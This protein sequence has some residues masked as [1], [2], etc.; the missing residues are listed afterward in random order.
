[1]KE[2]H[3]KLF[4]EEY[5]FMYDSIADTVDRKNEINPM[6]QSYIDKVNERRIKLGV[7][8]YEITD[9]S[10][11]NHQLAIDDTSLIDSELYVERLNS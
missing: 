8:P 7:K 10:P 9:N 2:L 6:S 11:R 3:L 4:P 5:D 1:M